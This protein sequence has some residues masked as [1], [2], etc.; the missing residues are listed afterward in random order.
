LR[1]LVF[2]GILTGLALPANAVERATVVQI[3]QIL[4]AHA[5]NNKATTRQPRSADEVAEITDSDLLPMVDDSALSRLSDIELTERMSTLT[6]YRLVGQYKL[7]AHA[8]MVLQQMAAITSWRL[9]R[10]CNIPSRLR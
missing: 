4:A 10:L 1:L 3:E 9:L 5:A 7:G 8:P 2:I 6:L